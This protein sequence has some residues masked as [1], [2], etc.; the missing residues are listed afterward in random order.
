MEF[1]FDLSQTPV[2][3]RRSHVRP[4]VSTT[5]SSTLTAS[6]LAGLSSLGSEIEKKSSTIKASEGNGHCLSPRRS[7][8]LSANDSAAFS[9]WKRPWMSQ[10]N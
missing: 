4:T 10:V 7:L 6:T 3:S 8:S 5:T 9:G 2:I 1:T